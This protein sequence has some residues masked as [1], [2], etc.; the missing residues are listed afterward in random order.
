MKKSLLSILLCLFSL[1]SLCQQSD[2]IVI[3]KAFDV[4]TYSGA[5]GVHKLNDLPQM[6]AANPEAVK[7]ADKACTNNTFALVFIYAGGFLIGWPLGTYASGGD[8]EWG[9][10][11]VG[12]GSFTAGLIF[13][14]VADKNARRAVDIYN[15]GARI[16]ESTSFNSEL[17]IGLTGNGVGLTLRF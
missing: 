3:V 1:A 8:A 14:K 11:A 16:P 2:S 9:L 15:S 5:G 17:G 13:K 10:L 4:L 12:A 7:Y 6:V